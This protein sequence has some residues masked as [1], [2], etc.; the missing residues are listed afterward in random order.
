MQSM[1]AREFHAIITDL[2]YAIDMDNLTNDQLELTRSEHDV[3]ENL[4]LYERLF[5]PM[6]RVLKENS[7]AI[8][9]I[10]LQHFSLLTKL[11]TEAGFSVCNW[12]L[13]W[14]KT[15]PCSNQAPFDNFTKTVENA[16]VLKKGKPKLC[17]VATRS[18]F[19][20]GLTRKELERF[21]H[22]FSKPRRL[23]QWLAKK[24]L[25][26][27]S[28][29]LDPFCGRGSMICALAEAGH[30]VFGIELIEDHASWAREQLAH[31]IFNPKQFDDATISL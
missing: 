5:A 26:P 27:G 1:P 22:P 18:D 23:T 10:D 16:I 21:V 17:E 24:I 11:A 31:S 9:F 3:D 28:L 2:P 13:T 12:P 6:Y 7:F 25:S 4:S 8:C 15:T 29:V 14:V 30:T 19:S 20:D